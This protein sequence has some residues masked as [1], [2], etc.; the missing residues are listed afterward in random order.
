[1]KQHPKKLNISIES[2]ALYDSVNWE[3]RKLFLL[4]FSGH[5][6]YSIIVCFPETNF[7]I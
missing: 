6:L 3:S 5:T 1:M 2:F 4:L 7:A